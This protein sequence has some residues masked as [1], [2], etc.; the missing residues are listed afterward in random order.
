MIIPISLLTMP[1]IANTPNDRTNI[2]V[3]SANMLNISSL[4]LCIPNPIL[5]QLLLICKSKIK[6]MFTIGSMICYLPLAFFIC[7]FY[8]SHPSSSSFMSKFAS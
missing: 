2:V 5:L 8:I 6:I 4:D 7:G 3:D 1:T